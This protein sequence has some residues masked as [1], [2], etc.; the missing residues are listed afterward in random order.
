MTIEER[1]AALERQVTLLM[2]RT[3][4]TVPIADQDGPLPAGA[5][6]KDRHARWREAN[7]EKNSRA[8]SGAQG[9]EEGN[10]E[11]QMSE[12]RVMQGA[13][14]AAVYAVTGFV[15]VYNLGLDWLI[16]TY[17]WW[18]WLLLVAV[19]IP[20]MA[21]AGVLLLVIAGMVVTSPWHRRWGWKQRPLGFG[22][23]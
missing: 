11:R 15:V 8:G 17:A 20:V 9:G 1:L 13:V 14:Y 10:G 7:R 3:V 4:P 19:G 23:P 12:E 18:N 5:V 21:F 16:A 2:R 6:E 22:G